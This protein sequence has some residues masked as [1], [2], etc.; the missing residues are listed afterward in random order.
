M[1]TD[2]LEE[3]MTTISEVIAFITDEATTDDLALIFPAFRTRQTRLANVRAA[4]VKIGAKVKLT[5]LSP[6]YLNGNTGTVKTIT[7]ARATVQLDGPSAQKL[8]G[9]KWGPSEFA[10]KPF[11]LPGTVP[12]K[13]L[14]LVDA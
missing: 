11:D 7:G 12:L 4:D 6:N 9:T 2:T 13:C 3:R 14:D 1:N 10:E 5:N 8:Y